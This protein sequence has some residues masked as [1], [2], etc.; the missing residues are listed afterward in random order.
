VLCGGCA[1]LASPGAPWIAAVTRGALLR[2]AEGGLGVA[3]G[4]AL[5]APAGRESRDALEAFLEH[6]LGKRL[7]A[8]R[9]LDEV[10]SALLE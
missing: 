7:A 2:L 1:S 9:F 5:A 10:G 8:R 6:H 3:A 4:E